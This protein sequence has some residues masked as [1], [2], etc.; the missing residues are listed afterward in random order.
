M[1]QGQLFLS[2]GYLLKGI[3][4]RDSFLALAAISKHLIRSQFSGVCGLKD[5][6]FKS[7][8]LEEPYGNAVGTFFACGTNANNASLIIHNSSL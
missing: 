1:L 3:H 8:K 6:I 4:C 7:L 5:N 2:Y